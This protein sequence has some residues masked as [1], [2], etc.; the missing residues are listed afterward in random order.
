MEY[1]IV[2]ANDAGSAS[3]Y[4]LDDF[5]DAIKRIAQESSADEFIAVIDGY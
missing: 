3:Y 2:W 5:I 1:R 4:N